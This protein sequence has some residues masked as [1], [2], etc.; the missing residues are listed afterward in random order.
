MKRI[1]LECPKCGHQRIDLYVKFGEA[2]PLCECGAQ[3][4]WLPSAG[5]TVIGDEIPGGYEIR[6]G[7]CHADGTPRKFY[8]HSE[9]KKEAAK[10]GLMNFVERGIADKKDYDRLTKRV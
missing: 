2:Y 3:M 6:H 8:S 10:R 1:D 4:E 5:G 7:L 9:I